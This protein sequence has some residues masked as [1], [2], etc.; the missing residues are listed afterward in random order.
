[1]TQKRI[2]YTHK[3]EK[4]LQAQRKNNITYINN[5]KNEANI[6]LKNLLL[7]TEKKVQM[8]KAIKSVFKEKKLTCPCNST[9]FSIIQVTYENFYTDQTVDVSVKCKDCNKIW[10]G[11]IDF[12]QPTK[13]DEE[14][15]TIEDTTKEKKKTKKTKKTTK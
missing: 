13:S 12:K 1:M 10:T 4:R 2:K 15:T 14:A 9:K 8:L 3:R 5:L 11:S 6:L 7:P